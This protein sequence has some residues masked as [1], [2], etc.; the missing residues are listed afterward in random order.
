MLLG[1]K[2]VDTEKVLQRIVTSEMNWC[3]L[4]EA[5][6]NAVEREVALNMAGKS[7]GGLGMGKVAPAGE[8]KG[9]GL[10]WS[11]EMSDVL[12]P[13]TRAEE[14]GKLS[15]FDPTREARMRELTLDAYVRLMLR[16]VFYAVPMN[17][18][19]VML[20]EFRHELVSMVAE[21]YNDEAKLRTVMSEELWRVQQRQQRTERKESLTDLLHKLD[22][23]S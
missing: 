11:A 22:L 13:S 17:I 20:N 21:K 3:F 4:S 9:N 16:R 1:K 2:K 12:S 10:H 19:N 5:D 7:S 8:A 23:L 18:R 6:L 15:R 14:G